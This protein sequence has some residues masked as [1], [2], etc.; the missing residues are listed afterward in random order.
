MRPPFT[1]K[2]NLFPKKS[3]TLWQ[4]VNRNV[5]KLPFQYSKLEEGFSFVN[6]IGWLVGIYSCH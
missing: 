4:N 5:M 1:K 6:R 3:V 2:K